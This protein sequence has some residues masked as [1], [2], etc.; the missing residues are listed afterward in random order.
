[1]R[2]HTK[3][4]IDDKRRTALK[5]EQHSGAAGDVHDMFHVKHG[6]IIDTFQTG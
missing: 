1:M 5:H 6:G 4:T 2:R 3:P